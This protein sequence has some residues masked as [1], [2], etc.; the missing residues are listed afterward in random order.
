M[1]LNRE[2]VY[3]GLFARVS[4]INGLVKKS[5]RVRSVSDTNKTDM[6]ALYQAQTYQRPIYEAG[7]QT[8]WELG[9]DIYI[10]AID[11]ADAP[12]TSGG[13]PMNGLLDGL[14]AALDF[15]NQMRNACTLGGLVLKCEITGIET[16]EGTMGEQAIAKVSINMLTRA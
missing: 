10:Y 15:D 16:D 11:R 2:A 12:P 7:R 3:A 9:A 1:P 6:P 5:R 13:A 14:Q 8:L 4:S